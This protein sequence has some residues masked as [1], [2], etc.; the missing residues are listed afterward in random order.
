V[1]A[2]SIY[3]AV[4][5]PR[6]HRR[7]WL[8]ALLF[9]SELG[10]GALMPDA[11]GL[12]TLSLNASTDARPRKERYLAEGMILRQSSSDQNDRTGPGLA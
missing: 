10:G 2:A 12:N 5:E 8:S 9:V 6:T 3:D 4:A 7:A 11:A 1:R